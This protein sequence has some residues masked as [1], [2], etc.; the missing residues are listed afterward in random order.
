VTGRA[1]PRGS[2]VCRQG[3]ARRPGHPTLR[4]GHRPHRR[5][6]CRAT[7]VKWSTTRCPPVRNAGFEAPASSNHG[8]LL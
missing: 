8:R 3:P 6:R 4:H 2:A 1:D 7:Q 5:E